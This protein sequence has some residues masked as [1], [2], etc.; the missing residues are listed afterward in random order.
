M[1][2]CVGTTPT[3]QRTMV[4]DRLAIDDVNRAVEVHEHASGKSVNVARVLTVLG[5]GA[6]AVGFYGGRRGE[7]LIE[8]MGQAGIGH[9]FVWTEAE[10]RLCT[11]VIDRSTHQATEL[12][13]EAPGATSIEWGELI[14]KIDEH[15]RGAEAVVFSGT[16]APGGPGD[17]CDRWIGKA[18]LV[19]VDAKGE[20]MRRALAAKGRVIAKLNRAEFEL[21][22]G[23][24]L[25]TEEKFHDAMRRMAPR[26]GWLIVTLGKAG[27][28]AWMAGELVRIESP[29]V[30]VVSAVGSGD[31]FTAG[32]VAAHDDTI[33]NALRLAS[34]C[35]AAN[36]MTKLS[37]VVMRTD[38]ERLMSEVRIERVR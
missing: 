8:D 38:V 10:T 5:K 31:A 30:E 2:L 11:T 4:F 13:E 32:L 14:E 28:V 37:G 7:Y 35:G 17:F 12:V 22:I 20:A 23:E 9:D 15:A 18:P 1:I 19:L 6:L 36:A 21:T 24:K 34:A 25:E 16:M 33:E 3:V 27:A 29:V 26:D